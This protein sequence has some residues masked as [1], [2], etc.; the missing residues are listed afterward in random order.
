MNPKTLL[1]VTAMLAGGVALT[2]V[3]LAAQLVV[4]EEPDGHV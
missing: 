3:V 2:L 4:I 1:G